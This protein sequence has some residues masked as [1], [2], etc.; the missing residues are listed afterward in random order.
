MG[1][2][3]GSDGV[4]EETGDGDGANGDS[5]GSGTGPQLFD[6]AGGM[7]GGGDEGG[8]LG[9]RGIDF[10]FIVDNSGSMADEQIA[11]VNSF[12][13]FVEGIEATLEEK[14]KDFHVMVVDSDDG[15]SMNPKA[16]PGTC[17]AELGAGLTTTV[18]HFPCGVPDGRRYMTNAD[19]NL[20]SA[21]GCLAYVGI[22]G[23]GGERPMEAMTRALGDLAGPGECNDGFLRDDAI[24]VVTFITDEE[25]TDSEGL[26]QE[27]V[28]AIVQAKHGSLDS[29]VML[30]LFGDGDLQMPGCVDGGAEIAPNLIAFMDA[31][32]DRGLRGRR[33]RR[34]LRAVLQR[35]DRDHRAGLQRL[36]PAGLRRSNTHARCFSPG[37]LDVLDVSAV[38]GQRPLRGQLEHAIG[39]RGEEVTIVGDEQHGALE[40]A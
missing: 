35:R 31:F 32:G 24:L 40:V 39:E 21:F 14:A 16:Q 9:C 7:E 34:G 27:W 26:S 19:P 5:D 4:D 25:D 17:E 36:R 15:N 23:N 28:D 13:G 1:S 3:S 22:N 37:G 8:E 10:L 18:T 11:L 6:V 38:V 12:P 29:I 30:G 20:P 33:L 2:G